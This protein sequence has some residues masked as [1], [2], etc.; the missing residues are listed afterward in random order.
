MNYIFSLNTLGFGI[1]Y[2]NFQ[3]VMAVVA[4]MMVLQVFTLYSIM[5]LFR[6]FGLAATM[7]RCKTQPI[8]PLRYCHWPKSSKPSSTIDLNQTVILKMEAIV[9]RK[10]RNKPVILEDAQTFKIIVLAHINR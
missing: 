7:S 9:P 10:R 4:Q 6:R 1:A 2:L 5:S 8:F 3:V